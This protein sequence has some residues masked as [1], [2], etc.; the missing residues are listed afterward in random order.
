MCFIRND[1]ADRTNPRVYSGGVRFILVY[2]YN[3]IGKNS[4]YVILIFQ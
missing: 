3:A 1:S 2:T 4:V